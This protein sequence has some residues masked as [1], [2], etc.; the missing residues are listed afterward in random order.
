M[1]VLWSNFEF[2]EHEDKNGS[3]Y[4]EVIKDAEVT[5]PGGKT[6]RVKKGDI[7]VV[8]KAGLKVEVLEDKK[9]VL[10]V[11]EDVKTSIKKEKEKIV[12]ANPKLI[13]KD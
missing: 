11:L 9:V 13:K 12:K 1:P 10:D 6:I 7:L 4:A 5:V 8:D 3:L 2:S